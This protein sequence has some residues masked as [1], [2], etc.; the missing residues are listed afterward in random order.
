[1]KSFLLDEDNDLTLD[2]TGNLAL[3]SGIEATAQTSRNFAA[4]RTGEMIHNA[5]QGIPFFLTSFDRF[6]NLAQFEAA[7]RRRLL[8]V[9]TVQ[10]VA[11]LDVQYEDG[12]VSYTATLQTDDGAVTING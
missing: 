10:A 11:A 6:P 8:Q 7:L 2:K 3:V 1:M 12:A 4:S 5:D 9:E